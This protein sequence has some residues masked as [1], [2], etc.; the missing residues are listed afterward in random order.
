[1]S[2]QKSKKSLNTKDRSIEGIASDKK[3][4]LDK[5]SIYRNKQVFN[6]H[7]IKCNSGNNMKNAQ[8]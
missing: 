1:M 7:P 6:N 4:K 2:N 5:L 3:E 8:T